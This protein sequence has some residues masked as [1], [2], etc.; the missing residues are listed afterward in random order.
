MKDYSP[1]VYFEDTA[2]VA[3][4]VV[5][6]TG[7]HKSYSAPNTVY[8]F[9]IVVEGFNTPISYSS[10]NEQVVID[11]RI[12]FLKDLTSSLSGE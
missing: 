1:F 4:K 10:R 12:K 11:K 2:I 6:V 3:N 7:I 8:R 5:I 9:S